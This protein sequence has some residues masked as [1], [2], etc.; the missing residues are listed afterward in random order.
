MQQQTHQLLKTYNYHCWLIGT[1]DCPALTCNFLK[2]RDF[3]VLHG[4][5]DLGT[6][7]FIFTQNKGQNS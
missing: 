1:I 6:F 7:Y 3:I 4:A 2:Q 5:V